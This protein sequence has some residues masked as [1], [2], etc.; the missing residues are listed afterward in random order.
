[1]TLAALVLASFAVSMSVADAFYSRYITRQWQHIV[2]NLTLTSTEW[3]RRAK[4]W[5]HINKDPDDDL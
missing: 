2:D 4:V 5:E 3:Q 1:M